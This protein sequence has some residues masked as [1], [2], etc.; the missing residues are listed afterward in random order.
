ME[1]TNWKAPP[2]RRVAMR[3]WDPRNEIRTLRVTF[4]GHTYS[5]ELTR[6]EAALTHARISLALERVLERDFEILTGYSREF[7]VEL[8]REIDPS[9]GPRAAT[10]HSGRLS[11]SEHT[12]P[13]PDLFSIDLSAEELAALS[14]LILASTMTRQEAWPWVRMEGE[15]ALPSELRELLSQ[16]DAVLSR[17]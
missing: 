4:E 7:A 14:N 15:S 12:T 1:G 8:S 5:V 6:K 9:S 16:I 3:Q 11:D 2:K 10:E 17:N 13:G